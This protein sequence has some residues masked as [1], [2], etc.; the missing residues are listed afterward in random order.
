M[1]EPSYIRCPICLLPSQR[2]VNGDR[3]E[4][5]C[6]RCGSFKITGTAQATIHSVLDTPDK[7][8]DFSSYLSENQH[9]LISTA[10]LRNLVPHSRPSVTSRAE[11]LLHALARK[12]PEPGLPIEINGTDLKTVL[13]T[14]TNCS[15]AST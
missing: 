8:L 4:F 12:F 9:L 13:E 11:A 14:L 5:A 1:K 2:I 3:Y 7:R 15:F 10:N 6:L